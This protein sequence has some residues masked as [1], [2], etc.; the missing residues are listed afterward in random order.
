M[1]ANAKKQIVR[2]KEF[3]QRHHTLVACAATGVITYKFTRGAAFK[4]ASKYVDQIAEEASGFVY[5][6]GR[7]NE[8]MLLQNRVFLDFINM[9]GLG[10][11][12]E[13]HIM[14]MRD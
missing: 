1:L 3:A 9:K 11:E 6:V 14:S 5:E 10:E 4:E 13:Q 7:E 12:L 2:A 8:H